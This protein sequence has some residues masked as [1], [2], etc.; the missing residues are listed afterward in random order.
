MDKGLRE[1]GLE[2]RMTA[3]AKFAACSLLQFEFQGIILG[4]GDA[5][6]EQTGE[7]EH[8]QRDISKIH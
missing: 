2:C 5:V 3:Q 1:L 6:A 4:K 7:H 8:N